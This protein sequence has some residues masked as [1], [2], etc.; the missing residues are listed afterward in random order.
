MSPLW[1]NIP[2]FRKRLMQPPHFR[3]ATQHHKKRC[4]THAH[5]CQLT[6]TL[7]GFLMANYDNWGIYHTAQTLVNILSGY[8]INSFIA[9]QQ[10]EKPHPPIS[11]SYTCKHQGTHTYTHCPLKYSGAVSNFLG[12]LKDSILMTKG[13]GEELSWQRHLEGPYHV[14]RTNLNS[15][16]N[17]HRE[18]D[19]GVAI[20]TA[21]N[22]KAMTN[23]WLQLAVRLQKTQKI[24]HQWQ[25]FSP[26]S[27]QCYS[28][29]G[30]LSSM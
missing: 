12:C 10:H 27:A 6:I 24:W 4:R 21:L 17:I 29:V 8:S 22:P 18:S 1:T 11:F 3:R 7:M 14:M 23:K 25:A 16:I 2:S 13:L 15:Q 28:T 30:L 20:I 26:S 9:K 19:W 5:N